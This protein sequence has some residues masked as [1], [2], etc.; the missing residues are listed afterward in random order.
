MNQVNSPKSGVPS[1][2]LGFLARLKEQTSC[3][4]DGQPTHWHCIDC[5]KILAEFRSRCES[6]EE[7]KERVNWCIHC[8]KTFYRTPAGN[9]VPGWE[10][11]NLCSERCLKMRFDEVLRSA[12]LPDL[13]ME[14]TLDNFEAYAPSLEAK[15]AFVRD[16]LGR[17]T[18]IGLF[19]YGRPGTGK[20][21]LAAGI[22]RALFCRSFRGSFVNA[23]KFVLDCQS[24]FSRNETVEGIV[25]PILDGNFLVLDDLGSEKETGYARQC[26]LHLVDSAYTEKKVLIVT[27]NFG[28]PAMAAAIDPRLAS[29]LAEMCDR[30]LFDEEDF[31]IRLA[32]QRIAVRKGRA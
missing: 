27:S 20:S 11:K 17:K 24:V 32:T 2:D 16:W 12:G 18:S 15:L 5:Q 3:V 21:H 30:L 22:M 1:N 14:K 10:T 7:R 4:C 26:L 9:P 8:C 19:L 29:R 6:C 28:L 13:Y 23:R 31:R 25:E